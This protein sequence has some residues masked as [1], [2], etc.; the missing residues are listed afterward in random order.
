MLFEYQS[1]CFEK[2]RID[3]S[4]VDRAVFRFKKMM[5]EFVFDSVKLEGNPFTFPEVKTLLDGVTVGG[6]RLSDQQQ[7][8]NQKRSCDAL[9][10]LLGTGTFDPLD[11]EQ[12]IALNELVAEGEALF[13]GALRDGPVSI[14]GTAFCPPEASG[15]K[16][17]FVDESRKI[18]SIQNPVERAYVYS[19]WA[20]VNQFFWDGNK[21]TGRLIMNGVLIAAGLDAL[22]IP[23]SCQLAYNQACMRLYDENDATDLFV[24]MS[25]RHV[26]IARTKGLGLH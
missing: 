21:R 26:E 23:A 6:H 9:L 10:R 4:G 24:L 7:V 5:P 8:L 15:L 13:T 20:A 25:N 18:E 14:A 3:P 22:T 11:M 17:A 1:D 2:N 19:A 16:F 12:W